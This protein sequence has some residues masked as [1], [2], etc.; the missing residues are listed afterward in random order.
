MYYQ[1]HPAYPPHKLYNTSFYYRK[2]ICGCFCNIDGLIALNPVCRFCYPIPNK[3]LPIILLLLFTAV[4]IGLDNFKKLPIIIKLEG[5]NIAIF[6]KNTHQW[7]HLI[8]EKSH[9]FLCR[10]CTLFSIIVPKLLLS[11]FSVMSSFKPASY[12]GDKCKS[13]FYKCITNI[14]RLLLLNLLRFFLQ[15]QTL[16][17]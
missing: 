17:L 10:I 2:C 11:L 5:I 1:L 8:L 4:A 13:C 15:V 12:N 9:F 16:F 6:A 7:I 3:E 14:L